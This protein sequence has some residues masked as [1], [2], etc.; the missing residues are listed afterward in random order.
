MNTAEETQNNTRKSEFDFRSRDISIQ[1]IS[2]SDLS[3]SLSEGMSDFRK[4]TKYGLFFGVVFSILGLI[5]VYTILKTGSSYWVLPIAAGF[6]LLGPFLAIGLYEISRRLSRGLP[7]SW[8]V[9]LGAVTRARHLQVPSMAFVVMFFYLIWVYLA[10]L[11]F[12][13]F[14]GI[15]ALTNISSS[16][17][18]LMTP[19]G[20]MMLFVGTIVGALLLLVLFSITVFSIPMFLDRDVDVVTGMVRSTQAV[21]KNFGT[22]I[23]WGIIVGVLIFLGIATYFIGFIFVFPLLGYASWHLYEKTIT[24]KGDA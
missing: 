2:V 13:L 18:E 11:I 23:I 8:D 20:M 3:A 9:V 1:K 7:L 10:H 12:A 14:F 4:S 19:E 6:P 16:F 24:S 15:K 5:I 17:E 21:M 22:M